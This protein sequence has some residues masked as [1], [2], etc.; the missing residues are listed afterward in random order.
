VGDFREME[1]LGLFL[2]AVAMHY[3]ISIEEQFC[4]KLI[5]KAHVFIA[6]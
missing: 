3:L 2:L 5:N 1:S 6:S 4:C